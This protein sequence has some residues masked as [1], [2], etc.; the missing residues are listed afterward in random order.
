MKQGNDDDNASD[1]DL[2]ESSQKMLRKE[3]RKSIQ[4]YIKN[5]EV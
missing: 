4:G 5:Q 1:S 3:L 2:V